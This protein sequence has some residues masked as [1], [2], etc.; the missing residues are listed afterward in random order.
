M[1]GIQ[2]NLQVSVLSQKRYMVESISGL[3]SSYWPCFILKFWSLLSQDLS[4]CSSSPSCLLSVQRL[5]RSSSPEQLVP[6]ANLTE[7]WSSSLL[8]GPYDSPL[9]YAVL[10]S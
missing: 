4:H 6:F 7:K 2:D 1:E 10:D 3:I 5:K 8:P 9:S